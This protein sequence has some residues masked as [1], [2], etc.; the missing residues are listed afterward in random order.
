MRKGIFIT[1]EGTD[2]S[3]KSTQIELIKQYFIE[4]KRDFVF[5]REPGGSEIGEKIREI[6]LDKDNKNMSVITEMLLYAA[7]RAQLVEEKIVKALEE[8]KVVI[9]DR[10]VDSSIVYQGIARGIGIDT[11]KKIN[12]IATNNIVADITFFFSVEPLISL[13]RIQNKV[14]DRLESEDIKFHEKVYNGYKFLMNLYP[15]RI[16]EID[17]KRSIEE[18]FAEV[19]SWLDLL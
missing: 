12:D 17:S 14:A 11:V 19:K 10:F 1:T 3:G 4:N 2:G 6:I 15:D 18:V 8:G 9:C 13:S 16:K 7:S 5:L